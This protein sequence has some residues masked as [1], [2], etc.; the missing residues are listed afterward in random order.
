MA[1]DRELGARIKAYR[2]KHGITQQ[3]FAA[4]LH[5]DH[6]QISRLEGQG[7]RGASKATLM[8]I[9]N[10]LDRAEAEDLAAE[11]PKSRT[12]GAQAPAS[13]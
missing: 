10:F 11:K 5:L 3:V 8:V 13:A 4:N 12:K 7:D 9:R 2:T 6:S 1:V